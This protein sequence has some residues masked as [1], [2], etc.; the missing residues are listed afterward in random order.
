MRTHVTFDNGSTARTIYWKDV[1]TALYRFGDD[2]IAVKPGYF[3]MPDRL[4]V[5]I[6]LG[7]PGDTSGY[8]LTGLHIGD[9]FLTGTVMCTGYDFTP[10]PHPHTPTKFP[11]ADITDPAA[12]RDAADHLSGIANHFHSTFAPTSK[13]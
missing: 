8:R 11:L 6:S 4:A 10:H 5:T 2:T 3:G 13:W 9:W 7:R 12:R 1:S